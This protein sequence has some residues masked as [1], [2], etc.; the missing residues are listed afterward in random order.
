[1]ADK[2]RPDVV[3]RPNGKAY[4]A[5]RVAVEIWD[6]AANDSWSDDYGVFVFGTHDIE[7]ARPLADREI[8]AHWDR[9]LV[10]TKPCKV[11][12][13]LGFDHGEF[14]W[15]TDEVKGRAAV[16]FTADYPPE[17]AS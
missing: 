11:W 5:R 14:V 2:V 10:A 1:M 12:K 3:I 7:L 13:R 6:N 16:C 15:W 4:R 9:D 8:K 17:A